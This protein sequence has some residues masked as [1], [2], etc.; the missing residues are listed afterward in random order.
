MRVCGEKGVGGR[1]EGEGEK[2]ARGRE[3]G[4]REREGPASMTTMPLTLFCVPVFN[5]SINALKHRKSQL[6]CSSFL[7]APSLLTPHHPVFLFCF[8]FVPDNHTCVSMNR[9][10]RAKI[11]T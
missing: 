11:D 9:H 3:G 5:E 2:E 10:A 1:E 6:S 8:Y 7:V 4:E